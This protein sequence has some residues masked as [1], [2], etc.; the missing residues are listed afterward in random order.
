[1]E[2][3]WA[4]AFHN[5][6][7]L[8]AEGV[9]R[10]KEL[11]AYR[12]KVAR[13][14]GAGQRDVIFT[15]GGTESD[16]LAII[17]AFEAFRLKNPGKRGHLIISAVEHPAVR[18]AAQEIKRRG[19]DVSVVEVDEDGRV[20]PQSVSKYLR[21]DTYLVSVMLANNEIGTIE[22]IAKI[23]RLIRAERKKNE[24]HYPYFHTD[25]SQGAN[26]IKLE[27][28]VLHVDMLTLDGSK[29]YGPKGVGIL[30]VRGDV[31]IRQIVWGGGQ[32]FGLRSGTESLALIAGFTKALEIADRDRVKEFQR[33]SV[34]RNHFIDTI[35]KSLPDAL[36]NAART[37]ALPNIVSVS[38][39][40]TIGE[41]LLLDLDRR[42][43]MVSVGSACSGPSKEG[44][45]QVIRAL[46]RPELSESTLR[47]SFG[48]ST[49]K[50]DVERALNIFLQVVRRAKMSS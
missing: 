19:G 17:G 5:P 16:N 4:D 29:I 21:A 11:E 1:M 41:V 28:E 42:G 32:E 23:G 50:R 15:S 6:S 37:E 46:G 33:L 48:R 27:A 2:R 43:V 7:S 40:D 30:L 9:C 34:L 25:A 18:E 38:I 39:P 13:L 12:A 31:S 35:E 14:L 47:F 45:S 3:Y 26:Y 49:T 36:I 22:P 8:Y 44:G 10:R 24:S 20:N